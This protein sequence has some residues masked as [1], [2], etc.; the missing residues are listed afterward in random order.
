[1][2]VLTQHMEQVKIN[3]ARD[4]PIVQVLDPA[5]PAERH[6]KPRIWMNV[7]VSGIG[8]LLVAVFLAFLLDY[9]Q[10]VRRAARVP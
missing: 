2:T 1:M 9:G 7:G 3:E 10:R 6:S 4:F 8:A 5:V